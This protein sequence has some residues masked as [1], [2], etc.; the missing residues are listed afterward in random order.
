LPVLLGGVQVLPWKLFVLPKTKRI[1]VALGLRGLNAV[2]ASV[3]SLFNPG[4]P[5]SRE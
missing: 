2:E 1:T 5:L 4:F 3:D